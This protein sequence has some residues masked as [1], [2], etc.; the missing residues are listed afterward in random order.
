DYSG[1]GLKPA[2]EMPPF[3]LSLRDRAAAFANLAPLELQQVLV[4][5]YAPGA[6]I[7]WHKDRSVFGNVLGISLVSNCLL[8]FR[9]EAG[10]KW[11]RAT[12]TVAPR[13]IYLLS[14]ASRHEW[15]HSIPGVEQ[16]RYSITFRQFA[17]RARRSA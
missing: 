10:G 3:L 4:T 15:Q 11:Q 2:D 1:G 8:R 5:E 17:S 6:A 14:G 13:S 16:L 9:R 12:L 7:G